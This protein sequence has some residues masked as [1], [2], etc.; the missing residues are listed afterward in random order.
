MEAARAAMWPAL[1]ALLVRDGSV[2]PAQLEEALL[3]KARSPELRLGEILVGRGVVTR[4]KVAQILALQHELDYIDLHESEI[5]PEA[6]GLLPENL[7]RRYVALP[8]RFLPDGSLVVAVADPTNVL[9][10]DELRLALGVPVRVGVAS[11]DA[12]EKAIER[13]H[14]EEIHIEEIAD[15]DEQ[16]GATILDLDGDTPT[17]VFV[18]KAIARAIDLGAS[19]IH[20]SPQQRRLVVRARVDGVVRDITS[21]AISSAAAV[22]SRLKIMG[23]LDIAER[24]APQDG[25]VS[26][27][28][29]DDTID[30]R[31]AVLPT[32][33]GEKVTM[34][35][36]SQGDAPAS[37]NDL[38][39]WP[40]SQAVLERA[41]SQPFG[42]VV[43]CG[44]TGAGKTTT[45]YACLQQLNDPEKTLVT[46]EDPV[47]YRAPGLDQIEVNPRAGL[48]FAS[49]LR[50]VLRSD[51]DIL[52]VGEI[53]DEETAQIA[54]RAAMTGHLVLTTVH[55]QTAA[56]ALQRLNDMHVDHGVLSTSLNCIVG[57]RLARRL[58]LTC[59]EPY[60]PE[61]AEL[62]AMGVP[63][64][65]SE[66]TLFRAVGCIDCDETGY[67]GRV[68]L[69]E[70][71]PVTDEIAARVGASTRDIEACAISQGMFTLRDDGIRLALAGITTLDEVRRVAG[72]RI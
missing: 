16:G 43:V 9:F 37:L 53:R 36:L 67:K 5:E 51:P 68:G 61:Q 60:H 54:F 14:T 63:A 42:A 58:C 1:G 39:M 71:M 69:Y 48:T 40:K 7:A 28:R 24:R 34:R 59:T 17:V 55:A 50:T 22:S 72:D 47:E 64:D 19:D 20:F 62:D 11:K 56:A 3:E 31:V 65:A 70:V 44:P 38:G 2:T 66:L 8:V 41:I 49:G 23:G 35:I 26:I 27:R 52:L 10:S 18:N 46:I 25:R 12:I 6:A 32:A 13:H 15:D 33:H 4:T 30:V 45:L 29:G 21:I 57:Q